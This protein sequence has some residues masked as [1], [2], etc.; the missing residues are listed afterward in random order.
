MIKENNL[1]KNNTILG[2]IKNSLE[3]LNKSDL[4]KS[5]KSRK[6]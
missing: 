3:K 6:A 5:K 1:E 4:N 2:I